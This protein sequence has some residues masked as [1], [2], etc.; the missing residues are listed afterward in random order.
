MRQFTLRL[1]PPANSLMYDDVVT[2]F[3]GNR[4]TI[5]GTCNIDR[6]AAGT[7]IG[8]FNLTQD[9]EDAQYVYYLFDLTGVI[10]YMDG[11]LI[12]SVGLRANT[13]GNSRIIED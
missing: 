10:P 9:V 4:Q 13:V 3:S 8:V 11:I 6:N 2:V 1:A 7:M 12:D 5:I